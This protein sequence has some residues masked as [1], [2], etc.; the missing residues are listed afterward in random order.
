MSLKDFTTNELKDFVKQ[1]ESGAKTKK[2]K[3]IFCGW[4]FGL[5]LIWLDW[6]S[7]LFTVAGFQHFAKNIE[8]GLEEKWACRKV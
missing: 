1:L 7:G 3:E 6:G 4:V 8:R 2:Q 5:L